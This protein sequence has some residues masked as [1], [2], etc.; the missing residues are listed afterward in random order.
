MKTKPHG[1][2]HLIIIINTFWTCLSS[3]FCLEKSCRMV[4]CDTWLPMANL[5]FSCFSIL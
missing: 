5:F 3:Y 4:C 1:D 2:T